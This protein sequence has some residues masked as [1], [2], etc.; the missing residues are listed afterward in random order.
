MSRPHIALYSHNGLAILAGLR[1]TGMWHAVDRD[2]GRMGKP[3]D[4]PWRRR[5]LH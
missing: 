2:L 4:S 1:S 3:D 5:P